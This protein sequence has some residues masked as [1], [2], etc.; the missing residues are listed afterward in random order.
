MMDKTSPLDP[1]M[2]ARA[3]R[4]SPIVGGLGHVLV[5]AGLALTVLWLGVVAWAVAILV[6]ATI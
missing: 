5:V 1:A 6:N 4:R 3:E 2:L